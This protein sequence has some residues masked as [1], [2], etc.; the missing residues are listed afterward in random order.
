MPDSPLKTVTLTCLTE[1][2]ARIVA[3]N[4]DRPTDP[5]H[6]VKQD[7][8][9]AVITFY[10]KRFPLNVASWAFDRGH[11]GDDD[12]ASVIAGL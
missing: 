2:D 12:A 11:A 4:M 6:R 8:A 10:D 7:G 1:E 9:K 3:V 5:N